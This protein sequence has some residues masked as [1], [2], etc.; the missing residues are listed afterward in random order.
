MNARQIAETLDAIGA[1]ARAMIADCRLRTTYER[2]IVFKDGTT[3]YNDWKCFAFDD[4]GRDAY[5]RRYFERNP[6]LAKRIERMQFITPSFIYSYVPEMPGFVGID[7][8]EHTQL[9]RKLLRDR[10]QPDETPVFLRKQA[11]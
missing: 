9:W 3:H 11:M 6:A 2:R 4:A 8:N 1:E 10:Q 5:A 7:C